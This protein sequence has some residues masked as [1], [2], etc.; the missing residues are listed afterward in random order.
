[1]KFRVGIFLSSSESFLALTNKQSFS[2]GIRVCLGPN[3]MTRPS[4]TNVSENKSHSGM[5]KLTKCEKK[6]HHKTHSFLSLTYIIGTIHVSQSEVIL[7]LM[8]I[9]TDVKNQDFSVSGHLPFCQGTFSDKEREKVE[10][11]D[12]VPGTVHEVLTTKPVNSLLMLPTNHYQPANMNFARN[13]INMDSGR[14]H[15]SVDLIYFP[16]ALN[17]LEVFNVYKNV[18]HRAHKCLW[19]NHYLQVSLYICVFYTTL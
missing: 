7:T 15:A 5:L 18:S 6:I 9:Y 17:N 8:H 16:A 1:M 3:W 2:H 12:A 11:K 4:V 13:L 19:F 14:L 10:A